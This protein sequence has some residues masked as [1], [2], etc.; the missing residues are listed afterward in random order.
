VSIEGRIVAQRCGIE[1]FDLPLDGVRVIP[2][3]P[4]VT[5][6]LRSHVE[7]ITIV[8]TIMINPRTYDQVV[9]GLVPE[10][11]AH[12]LI[13]VAQ[14]EDNGIFGFAWEYARDYLRLRLL[15]ASHDAA[16]RSIGFEYQAFA[17]AREIA[18]VL[19]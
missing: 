3:P 9:S 14:W 10:L 7:A 13:H 2:M 19:S 6:A 5:K 15:G 18:N 1:N 16:Y 4:I 17:G 11:V 12:E 8:H